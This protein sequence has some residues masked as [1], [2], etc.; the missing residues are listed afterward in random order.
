MGGAEADGQVFFHFLIGSNGFVE[1]FAGQG[2]SR[3]DDGEA[4]GTGILICFGVADDFFF[5]EEVIFVDVGMVAGGLR[6]VFAVFT[7]AAAASVEDGAEVDML[8]TE[9]VLQTQSACLQFGKWCREKEG[10]VITA[11]DA[12]AGND[13]VGKFSDI[14]EKTSFL[15]KSEI[16]HC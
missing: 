6:A 9:V 4:V 14:H 13:L 1:V 7:A 10:E 11:F 3:G 5:G 15:I 2:A 8:A 12:A 16:L